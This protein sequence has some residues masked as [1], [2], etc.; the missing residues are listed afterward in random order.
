[1]YADFTE[2][3]LVEKRFLVWITSQTVHMLIIENCI[4][5]ELLYKYNVVFKYYE[6]SPEESRK[7]YEN[8][9]RAVY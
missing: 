5:N 6:L 4:D 7:L 8:F 3:L 2:L 1:M 9:K